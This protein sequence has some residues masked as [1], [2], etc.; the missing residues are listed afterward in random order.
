MLRSVA[1]AEE[2]GRGAPRGVIDPVRVAE[3]NAPG[4][5]ARTC[6]TVPRDISSSTMPGIK[7]RA[8]DLVLGGNL[9]RMMAGV[10]AKVWVSSLHEAR[11]SALNLLLRAT[12]LGQEA[13]SA[14]TVR[15]TRTRGSVLLGF[16]GGLELPKAGTWMLVA[17]SG[18]EWGC[19]IVS[20]G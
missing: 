16:P 2:E 11:G 13:L 8:G 7:I 6:A 4:S 12:R 19:V 15:F 14:D 20:V 3:M 10:E 18:P 17:T 9:S 1:A 5:A